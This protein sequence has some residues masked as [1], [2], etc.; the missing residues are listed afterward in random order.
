MR[1]DSNFVKELPGRIRINTGLRAIYDEATFTSADGQEFGLENKTLA[2]RIGGRYGLPSYTFSIPI[3]DLGTG[4]AEEEGGGWGL[5]LRLFRR[6]GYLRTAFRFTDG[7]RLTGPD[8]DSEFREDIRLFSAFLYGY[9]L[10][11]HQRYSLRASFN[12]RDVQL[13]NQGS[14]LLGGLIT[15]RR[16]LADSLLIPTEE[17]EL[18]AVE[19]FAQTSVGIGGGYAYTVLPFN[20]FYVTPVVYAGPELRFTLLNDPAGGAQREATRLG[21]QLRA[22]LSVGYNDGKYF[23]GVVADYIPSRDKTR[24]ISTQDVRSQLE[25]RIGVQW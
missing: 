22:R 3:S 10:F 2:Y 15:R 16:L 11:N 1:R 21:L 4:T 24:T 25:L 13:R 8:G 18:L 23:A 14:W 12:Q 5:G 19:R 20:Y 7:F 6:Y 17:D 9:H